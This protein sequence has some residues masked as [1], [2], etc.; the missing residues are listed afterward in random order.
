MLEL[1]TRP[2]PPDSQARPQKQAAVSPLMASA[3]LALFDISCLSIGAVCT[4]LLLPQ[5]P[6][7]VTIYMFGLALLLTLHLQRASRQYDINQARE[8]VLSPARMFGSWVLASAIASAPAVLLAQADRG[9]AYEMIWFTCAPCMTALAGR[10]LAARQILRLVR[11]GYWN[12]RVV[13]MG[14]GEHG[15]RLIRHLQ[16]DKRPVEIIGLFDDRFDRLPSEVA[17]VPVL[18]G[19]DDLLR[20][21]R[22]HPV[23]EVVVALPKG[24]DK[25]LAD[26]FKKLSVLPL[27]ITHCQDVPAADE[28]RPMTSIFGLPAK[29]LSH[30]PLDGWGALLKSLE[31]RL[32][33]AVFLTIASPLMLLIALAV[34]LSSEGPVLFRQKRYGFNNDEIEVLKFRTM[35]LHEGPLEQAKRDDPRITPLGGLLRKTSLDELPQL[36]NVL[37]GDMSLVGPRPH[38]VA[39][40][41][42][43]AR[44]IDRYLCRHRV[45]PGITGWAQ[46]NGWRGETDT[47]EKM[48]ARVAHDL[49]YIERWS[50]WFDLKIIA[51]TLVVGFRH[52]NA[53]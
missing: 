48:E 34:K 17:S 1:A 7:L 37:K 8:P 43:Y 3:L 44:S 25:R 42:H 33:A 28:K 24:A 27:Q 53:Y 40:N 47:I 51:L 9:Q 45:K 6:T 36:I 16:N 38:A 26:W 46:V 18:G 21:A 20:F 31:D 15:Q 35:R 12:S 10:F 13:I 11:G 29:R 5:W 22:S 4:A 32:L 14:G 49:D 2:K 19:L 30:K 23:D 41:E 50:L 39:H 52:P